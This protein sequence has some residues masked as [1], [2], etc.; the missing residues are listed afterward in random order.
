MPRKNQNQNKLNSF[1]INFKVNEIQKESVSKIA[2]PIAGSATAL[3]ETI[4]YIF[5]DTLLSVNYE[6]AVLESLSA[7]LK[8]LKPA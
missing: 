5:S 3:S 1:E 7:E 6:A 2:V 8:L 4:Q